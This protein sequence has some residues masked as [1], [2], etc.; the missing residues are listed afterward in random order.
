M[1]WM[2]SL[3]LLVFLEL[4]LG[5]ENMAFLTM[6]TERLPRRRRIRARW[7]GTI[8]ALCFRFLF[9]GGLSAVMSP[10]GSVFLPDG[11]AVPLWTIILLS[12]GAF[13]LY[14]SIKEIRGALAP[15]PLL[16]LISEKRLLAGV[17]MQ[18]LAINLIFSVASTMT[19]VGLTRDP[20]IMYCAVAVASGI[21]LLASGPVGRLLNKRV[22]FKILIPGARALIGG[23]LLSEGLGITVPRF[24]LIL[25]LL[26]GFALA[27]TNLWPRGF[28]S[29]PQ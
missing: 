12:G 9:L 8:L 3:L 17:S 6:V 14:Q 4:A 7:A 26:L 27:I 28:R 11:A 5:L 24:A 2:A 18:V 21:L 22:L 19:A 15:A 29:H 23:T 10:D 1:E 25:I 16:V 13:L 20:G